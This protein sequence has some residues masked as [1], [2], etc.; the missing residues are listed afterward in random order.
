MEKEDEFEEMPVK[1]REFALIQHCPERIWCHRLVSLEKLWLLS[2]YQNAVLS[3]LGGAYSACKRP[4]EAMMLAKRQ[5]AVAIRL[6]SEDDIFK[7]KVF[8]FINLSFLGFHTYAKYLMK[9]CIKK[10]S[11][12]NN[13][14]MIK[15][16]E[17]NWIWLNNNQIE[18]KK[19]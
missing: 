5:E 3:T 16:I 4:Y 6:S 11:R 10:A 7:A 17:T 19:T 1:E 2:I 12:S 18:T 8:Q 13:N 14:N 9:E 15:H